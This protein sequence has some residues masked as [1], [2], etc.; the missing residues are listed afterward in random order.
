MVAAQEMAWSDLHAQL[1]QSQDTLV[2]FGKGAL[3]RVPAA[4]DDAT[5]TT[6]VNAVDATVPVVQ[7]SV[8]TAKAMTDLFHQQDNQQ[9]A[10]PSEVN[11]IVDREGTAA[12]APGQAARGLP[13]RATLLALVAARPDP[14]APIPDHAA[15]RTSTGKRECSRCRFSNH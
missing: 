5:S 13:S 8:A 11:K 2:C 14:A 6:T 1:V 7:C 3:R 12:A 9:A 4:V 15:G 10:L